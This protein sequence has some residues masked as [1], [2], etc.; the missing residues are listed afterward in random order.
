MEFHVNGRVMDDDEW[1]HLEGSSVFRHFFTFLDQS[2]RDNALASS[3][4]D[5]RTNSEPYLYVAKCKD[6]FCAAYAHS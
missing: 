5:Q 4:W 3:T 6:E 1:T 2:K